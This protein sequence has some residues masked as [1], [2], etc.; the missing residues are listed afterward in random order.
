[1]LPHELLDPLDLD[2][3]RAEALE[4]DRERRATPIAYATWIWQRSAS[5]AATTFFAT[6]RTAYDAERSTL[7]DPCP[8]RRRRHGA[9]PP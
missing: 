2:A 3:L 9:A 8:R 5:P 1:M 7:S 6:W 4:V